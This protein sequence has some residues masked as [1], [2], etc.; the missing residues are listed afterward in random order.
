MIDKGMD[1]SKKIL[2]SLVEK[3]KNRI[4]EIKSGK[5]PPIKPDQNAKYF[6]E[7]TVD[8]DIIDEPMIADQMLITRIHQKYTHDT[9]RELSYY[10]GKRKLTLDL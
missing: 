1:N 6:A 3:A 5:K 7:F 2:Q 4:N 8:L 10:K 9:I